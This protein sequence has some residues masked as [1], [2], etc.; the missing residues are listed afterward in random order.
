MEIYEGFADSK[1]HR[2][3]RIVS[4][5][6]FFRQVIFLIWNFWY[7]A[8]EITYISCSFLNHINQK[9][10]LYVVISSKWQNNLHECLPLRPT[11]GSDWASGQQAPPSPSLLFSL[12]PFLFPPL[13]LWIFL[14]VLHHPEHFYLR[15]KAIDS[16]MCIFE[17]KKK[18]FG[19]S[20][21]LLWLFWKIYHR[22]LNSFFIELLW[23]TANNTVIPR[24]S[25]IIIP[26]T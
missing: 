7:N 11:E 21:L 24:M 13:S 12:P 4:V 17:K 10:F 6:S 18:T 5:I 16:R 20:Y 15:Q 2:W 8:D 14:S 1:H 23:L 25:A 9:A 22:S 3:N 26:R 19:F